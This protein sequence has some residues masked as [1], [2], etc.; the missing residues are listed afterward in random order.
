MSSRVHFATSTPRRGPSFTG[1]RGHKAPREESKG[2]S[3]HDG[4]TYALVSAAAFLGV[5]FFVAAAFFLGAALAAGALVVFVTRPDLVFPDTTGALSSTAGAYETDV[6]GE[7]RTMTCASSGGSSKT[8]SRGSLTHLA[9]VGLGLGGRCLLGC[10]SLLGGGSLGLRLGL[11]FGG[12][13]LGGGGG[14]LCGGSSLLGSGSFGSSSLR[15]GLGLSSRL[16]GSKLHGSRR[17]CEIRKPRG[18]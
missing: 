6:S 5:A 7:L 16:A 18:Q 13:S 4:S 17:S 3:N 12:S 11:G 8:Y 9:S 1:E 10:R 2:K 14:L 15:L